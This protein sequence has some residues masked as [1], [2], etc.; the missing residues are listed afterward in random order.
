VARQYY[1]VY[2]VEANSQNSHDG[3]NGIWMEM[4]VNM[5]AWI[6]LGI[7]DLGWGQGRSQVTLTRA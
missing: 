1:V 2:L 3:E 4:G 5:N 6:P 7:S